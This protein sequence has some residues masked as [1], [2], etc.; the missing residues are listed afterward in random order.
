MRY[1]MEE[2]NYTF[3]VSKVDEDTFEILERISQ[4]EHRRAQSPVNESSDA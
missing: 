4:E 3:N 2:A 1:F